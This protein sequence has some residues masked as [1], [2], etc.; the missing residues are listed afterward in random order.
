MANRH[1][2]FVVDDEPVIGDTLAAILNQAGYEASSFDN[3]ALAVASAA[4]SSPDLLI[5]DVM[6]PGMNGVEL[7][8]HFLNFHPRCKVLLFSGAAATADLLVNARLR[9]YDFD[10]L[11]KPIHPAKLIDKLKEL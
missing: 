5:S 3:P 4:E 10:L 9:G 11:N 1:T 8:I 7:A 2:V 6:M